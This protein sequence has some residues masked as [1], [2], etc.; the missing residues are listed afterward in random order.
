ME[1]KKFDLEAALRGEPVVTRGGRRVVEIHLFDYLPA[2]R[3]VVAV[4]IDEKKAKNNW[5]TFCNREGV[6]WSSF[7]MDLFM[8]SRK[9]WVLLYL[10]SERPVVNK[11]YFSTKDAAEKVA[12]V[13]GLD[14]AISVEVPLP[15]DARVIDADVDGEEKEK[16]D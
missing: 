12:Q 4:V 13:I 14:S 15:I 10:D 1:L 11:H 5:V 3:C 2:E 6:N 9:G 16:N 8:A 7:G